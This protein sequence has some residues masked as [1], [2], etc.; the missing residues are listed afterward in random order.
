MNLEIIFRF[1]VGQVFHHQTKFKPPSGASVV[2]NT[3][4]RERDDLYNSTI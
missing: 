3:A 4:R 2:L 1:T